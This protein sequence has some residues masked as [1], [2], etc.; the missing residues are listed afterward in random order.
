[1]HLEFSSV[2]F[3]CIIDSKKN[4]TMSQASKFIRTKIMMKKRTSKNQFYM[5]N[6]DALK[7][8]TETKEIKYES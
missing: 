1:M 6:V 2:K 7:T 3:N 4:I 5:E 8:E